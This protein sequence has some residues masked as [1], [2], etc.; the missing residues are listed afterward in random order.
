[1]GLDFK[2]LAEENARIRAALDYIE[3]AINDHG[4]EPYTVN[5]SVDHQVKTDVERILREVRA[6]PALVRSIFR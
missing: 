5:V 6:D 2:K 1:M 4:S 3:T